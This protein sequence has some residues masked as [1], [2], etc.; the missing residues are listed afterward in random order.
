MHRRRSIAS[1]GAAITAA[2]TLRAQQ[3]VMPVIGWLSALSPAVQGGDRM[4]EAGTYESFPVATLSALAAFAKGLNEA[5][6]VEG[7]NLAIEYPH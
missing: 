2:R 7:K 5:G 3:K 4:P 1:L 6:Y